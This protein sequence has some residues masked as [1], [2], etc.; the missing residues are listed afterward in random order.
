MQE[1]PLLKSGAVAQYPAQRAIRFSTQVMRF[2]DGSD[3]GT[4]N[5]ADRCGGGSSS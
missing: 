4:A 1:F 5:S 3:N 2:V